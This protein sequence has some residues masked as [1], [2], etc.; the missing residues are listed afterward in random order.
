MSSVSFSPATSQPRNLLITGA[1]S[2]IGLGMAEILA[3]YGHFVWCTDIT[4]ERAEAAAE[5][6]RQNGGRATGLALDV[7]RQEQID[8]LPQATA[9]QPV[10]VLINNAG[11]QHVARIEEFPPERF[12]LLLNIM[13]TAP[14]MLC[15]A[16]LPQMRQANYGRIINVGSIHSLIASPYKSAYVAAKHGLMG[17]T[18]V[19]ALETADCDVTINTLCPSYVKTPLVEQQIAAQAQEHGIPPEQVVSEIMLKPMPKGEFIGLEEMADYAQFLISPSA[20][21]ITG[22]AL[23][24]DGAWTAR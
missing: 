18:K 22:Q 10:A 6:I 15:R 19:L 2:G 17:L 4:L 14:A 11:L 7:T 23:V 13:L 12:A 24:L 20:R 21:H 9:S 1:G 3:A 16:L 8:A 5:L